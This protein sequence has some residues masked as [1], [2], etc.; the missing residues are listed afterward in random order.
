MDRTKALEMVLRCL[1]EY[2]EAHEISVVPSEDT[3]LVGKAAVIDSMGLVNLIIDIE[4]ILMDSGFEISLT[5]EAAM[6]KSKSPFRTVGTLS[7][8][9]CSSL[10]ERE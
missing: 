10:G 6:S 2:L 7:D 4:S 3:V 5:S 9:V 1:T 8:F